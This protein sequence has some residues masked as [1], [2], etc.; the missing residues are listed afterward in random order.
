M[1]EGLTI[2]ELPKVALEKAIIKSSHLPV[3]HGDGNAKVNL[4]EF[5]A[6]IEKSI[7]AAL[8]GVAEA[9]DLHDLQIRVTNN[10]REI[11]HLKENGVGSGAS[12]DWEE[13]WQRNVSD[14]TAA[15]ASAGWRHLGRIAVSNDNANNFNGTLNIY[16]R[17]TTSDTS[18]LATMYITIPTYF[19]TFQIRAGYIG[20]VAPGIS[21]H[22]VQNGSGTSTTSFDLWLR[23]ESGSAAYAATIELA[24]GSTGA[25]SKPDASLAAPTGTVQIQ[26]IASGGGETGWNDYSTV[27]VNVNGDSSNQGTII[28]LRRHNRTKLVTVELI[29][30]NMTCYGLTRGVNG[31]P[32]G[33]FPN[34]IPEGF[35]PINMIAGTAYLYD[36]LHDSAMLIKIDTNGYMWPSEEDKYVTGTLWFP[37]ISWVA[38]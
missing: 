31:F 6:F 20:S 35:R 11:E 9:S 32:N 25:I 10:E 27:D 22:Y 12:G 38:A 5:P 18:L 4:N 7:S 36:T 33:V 8:D 29:A 30:V 23:R 15:P 1:A 28:R 17:S 19:N 13:K 21:L 34:R 2:S 16:S 26:S 24:K 3:A 14:Y 37:A